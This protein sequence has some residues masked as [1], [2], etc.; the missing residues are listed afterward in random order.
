MVAEDLLA[1]P[2]PRVSGCVALEPTRCQGTPDFSL[3]L[4]ARYLV[5]SDSGVPLAL[6]TL[7]TGPDVQIPV[8]L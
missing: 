3:V 2:D 6:A 1:L 8:C 5:A 7:S 4:W